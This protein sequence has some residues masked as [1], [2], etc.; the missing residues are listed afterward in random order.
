M[1]E[2]IEE[3]ENNDEAAREEDFSPDGTGK[4]ETDDEVDSEGWVEVAKKPDAS[5]SYH[6]YGAQ[7]SYKLRQT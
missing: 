5:F 6:R 4:P 7:T 3:A 2:L 1:E